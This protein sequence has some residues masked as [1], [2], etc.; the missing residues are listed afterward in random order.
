M[1]LIDSK[2]WK[3]GK[4]THQVNIYQGVTDPRYF[5]QYNIY[6]NGCS[7]GIMNKPFKALH[8]A[9]KVFSGLK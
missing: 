3:S 9:R 7:Q 4:A 5:V 6:N 1:S 8:G 2:T